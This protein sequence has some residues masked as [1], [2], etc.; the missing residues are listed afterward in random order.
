MAQ[1]STPL[2]E[3]PDTPKTERQYAELVDELAA[4]CVEKLALTPFE[5]KPTHR[6]VQAAANARVGSCEIL[7]EPD[8]PAKILQFSQSQAGKPLLQTYHNGY[9]SRQK[10]EAGAVLT[11]DVIRETKTRV[12]TA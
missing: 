8:A 6:S 11:A 5:G 4:E 12:D 1:V 3:A 9:E 2:I 7:E 10:A